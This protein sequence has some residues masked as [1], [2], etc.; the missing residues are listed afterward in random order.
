[1]NAYREMDTYISQYNAFCNAPERLT[2]D[3]EHRMSIYQD[4]MNHAIEDYIE[5]FKR[6]YSAGEMNIC[7]T[8]MYVA[9]HRAVS[10]YYGSKYPFKMFTHEI[11]KKYVANVRDYDHTGRYEP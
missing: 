2:T 10:L 1:M 6:H 5:A 11:I 7:E 8:M 9:S 4:R 3:E